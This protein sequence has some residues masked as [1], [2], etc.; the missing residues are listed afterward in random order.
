MQDNCVQ[1]GSSLG[2]LAFM[3]GAVAILL[4][5]PIVS[6]FKIVHVFGWLIVLE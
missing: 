3:Y 5:I 4:G 1:S 6:D 2:S